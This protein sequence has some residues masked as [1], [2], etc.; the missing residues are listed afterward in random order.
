MTLSFKVFG[1]E[2]ARVEL[3]LG[4]PDEPDHT[5]VDKATK[6]MSRQWVKRM[7]K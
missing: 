7:V 4:E 5:P 1:I 3:D 6:W 2:F